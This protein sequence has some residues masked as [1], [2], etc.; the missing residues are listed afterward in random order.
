[1]G[2]PNQALNQ[3]IAHKYFAAWMITP[4][5]DLGGRRPV[6]LIKGPTPIEWLTGSALI[7]EAH[8]NRAQ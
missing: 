7:G 5:S 3:K 8:E 6:D 1:M 4:D 2:L